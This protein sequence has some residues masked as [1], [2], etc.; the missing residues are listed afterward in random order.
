M[1]TGLIVALRFKLGYLKTI[2]L[3][4]SDTPTTKTGCKF[5]L[6]FRINKD[7]ERETRKK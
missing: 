1:N 7:G 4:L 6:L 2:R 3:G 5:Q